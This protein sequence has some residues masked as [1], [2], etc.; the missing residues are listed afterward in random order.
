MPH[1][2][3]RYVPDNHA[4]AI[5]HRLK[6]PEEYAPVEEEKMNPPGRPVKKARSKKKN[7]ETA[8]VKPVRSETA[9]EI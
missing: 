8:M 9:D 1:I 6:F 2:A 5:A 7:A 3:G 4:A